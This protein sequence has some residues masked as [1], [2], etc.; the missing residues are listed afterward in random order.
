[1]DR[2]HKPSAKSAE[3]VQRRGTR[4]RRGNECFRFRAGGNFQKIPLG[5]LAWNTS[6]NAGSVQIT[7]LILTQ[8]SAMSTA[9]PAESTTHA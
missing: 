7:I 4:T 8:A 3:P 1:M 6:A 9:H 5:A 2:T